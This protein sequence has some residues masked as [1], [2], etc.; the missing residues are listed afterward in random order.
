MLTSLCAN[1]MVIACSIRAAIWQGS[2]LLCIHG[3]CS[4]SS[5]GLR[6]DCYLAQLAVHAC[7]L[8]VAL[9]LAAWRQSVKPAAICAVL[10]VSFLLGTAKVWLKE[11]SHQA[12]K[13]TTSAKCATP[14]RAPCSVMKTFDHRHYSKFLHQ[15]GCGGRV[16][17]TDFKKSDF[18]GK[19]SVVLHFSGLLQRI[20]QACH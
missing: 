18:R 11:D 8:R 17:R 1:V 13:S 10:F 20:S 6:A 19:C 16:D 12:L 7:C 3:T 2:R 4:H 9:V 14:K 5:T 15:L